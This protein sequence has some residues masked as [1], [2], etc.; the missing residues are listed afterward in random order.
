MSGRPFPTVFVSLVAAGCAAATVATPAAVT[1]ATHHAEISRIIAQWHNPRAQHEDYM[2]PPRIEQGDGSATP[3]SI[4]W[5]TTI[6]G[7]GPTGF[8]FTPPAPDTLGLNDGQ[9]VPL[10]SLLLRN[11]VISAF[12]YL[13]DY[14]ELTLDI[15][16]HINGAVN[17]PF[18]LPLTYALTYTDTLND[19]GLA[20]CPAW[21]QSTVPCDDRATATLLTPGS[22]TL[23]ANGESYTFTVK[24]FALGGALQSDFILQE[25]TET[26]VFLHASLTRAE[27]DPPPGVIPLPGALPLLL[28]ALGALA[29]WR[30]RGAA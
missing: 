26:E 17:Q 1:A 7:Y 4:H 8:V 23:S 2:F 25:Q 6:P 13:L 10:A 18:H 5:S 28:G 30:S 24:G 9:T 27:L 20:S 16:G 19:F 15:H 22:T 3:A 12:G 21:Q 29:L 11:G 14:V